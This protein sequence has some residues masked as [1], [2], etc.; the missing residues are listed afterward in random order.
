MLVFA[1]NAVI[2][3]SC[4]AGIGMGYNSTHHLEVVVK[5]HRHGH[6]PI[7]AKEDCCSNTLTKLTQAEKT[8]PEVTRFIDPIFFTAPVATYYNAAILLLTH[9]NTVNKYYLHRYHPP[10]PDI[11]IAIRSFRI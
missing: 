8:V 6:T 10:I 2:S 3:I 5:E 1:L 9:I 11:C 4:A 7:P